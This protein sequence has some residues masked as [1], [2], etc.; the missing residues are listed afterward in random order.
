ME[1]ARE[2]FGTMS[3]QALMSPA[4]ALARDGYT[5]ESGDGLPFADSASEGY[6]SAHTFASQPNERAIFMVDG[7]L[8]QA[9]QLLKQPARRN[10]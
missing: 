9:G 10:A 3:R 7:H 4:I 2:E 8:P 1:T 5:F 6:G